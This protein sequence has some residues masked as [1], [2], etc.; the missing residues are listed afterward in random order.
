MLSVYTDRLDNKNI[1]FMILMV[2]VSDSIVKMEMVQLE[3]IDKTNRITR[4]DLQ[5]NARLIVHECLL[6]RA[7]Q[8]AIAKC[9]FR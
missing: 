1:V 4:A 5:E 3:G 9:L 6:T 7:K 8:R 2:S